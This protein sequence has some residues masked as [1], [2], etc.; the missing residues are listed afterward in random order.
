MDTREAGVTGTGELWARGPPVRP[1]VGPGPVAGLQCAASGKDWGL[2]RREL[3]D[4]CFRKAHA[5]RW[6]RVRQDRT[7][8]AETDFARRTNLLS[9]IPGDDDTVA[10]GR[11]ADT[12]MV[13]WI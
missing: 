7:P 5:R 12:E 4:R 10:H 6:V 11:G 9:P 3:T 13:A 1:S 8:P 2:P